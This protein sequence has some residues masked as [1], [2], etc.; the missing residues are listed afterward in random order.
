MKGEFLTIFF[1]V[2]LPQFVVAQLYNNTTLGFNTR[3]LVNG[4]T[5][6]NEYYYYIIENDKYSNVEINERW[7]AVRDGSGVSY[8]LP[9][10]ENPSQ[11]DVVLIATFS[12]INSFHYTINMSGLIDMIKEQD[13]IIFNYG[14][15]NVVKLYNIPENEIEKMYL[16]FFVKNVIKK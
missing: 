13:M 6:K 9:D 11:K 1:L 14:D 10:K 3:E 16:T 15:N 2:L 4:N 7:E 12:D 8:E 5:G